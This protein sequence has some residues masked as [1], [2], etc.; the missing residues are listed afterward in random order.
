MTQP[1]ASA[2]QTT[3]TAVPDNELTRLLAKRGTVRNF[4]PDPVP[5]E[6]VNAIIEFGMRAPS[7][8]NREEYS[9]IVVHDPEARKKLA[10]IASNQQHIIDCP[11][12]FAICADQNRV[13]QA[14]A[15]HGA[16]YPARNFEAG[17]V[18]S[19]D[20]ALVGMTM[21]LV[22]DS[23]GLANVMIGAMRNNA[24][25]VAEVL[26]LPPR[27]YVVFGL[28]VG[29]PVKPPLPK[30]RHDPAAVVHHD[31]YDPKAHAQCVI[32]YDKELA[33]YYRR[34]GL[35]T[36]DAAWSQVMVEKYGTAKRTKLKDQLIALGFPLE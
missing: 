22:A 33:A 5:E 4:K 7:S 20:A 19:I 9:I 3:S 10:K 25:A 14:M 2:A 26:K 13:A 23:F 24:V 11:V 27:C 28:C 32:D 35:E 21:S 31:I 12:F 15:M 6:W 8:S 18:A 30:P 36:P 29:F 34:R 17:L 16:D 1:T